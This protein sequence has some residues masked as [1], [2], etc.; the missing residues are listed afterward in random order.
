[1]IAT[2]LIIQT[3]L[4]SIAEAKFGSNL[5][6]VVLNIPKEGAVISFNCT[7]AGVLKPKF[8]ILPDG[9]RIYVNQQEHNLKEI[10]ERGKII[11]TNDYD[12]IQ[13]I[14][15]ISDD[16]TLRNNHSSSGYNFD[17]ISNSVNVSGDLLTILG[18]RRGMDGQYICVIEDDRQQIFFIPYVIAQTDYP[19][20]ML[21]SACVSLGFAAAC[22]IILILDRYFLSPGRSWRRLFSRK[23]RN[24][25]STVNDQPMHL[26]S[27]KSNHLA[28]LY[29]FNTIGNNSNI[30]K[31]N[32]V[33]IN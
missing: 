22:F 2:S 11:S 13:N 23:I 29:G 20:S 6:R 8:W 14:T 12:D 28:N 31:N 9:Q 4:F 25:P 1:M 15:I 17:G 26:T 10:E 21:L 19:K 16:Y 32:Y 3:I 18:V 33:D 30:M 5:M 27:R 7:T 24:F